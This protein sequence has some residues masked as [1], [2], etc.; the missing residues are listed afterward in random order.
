MKVTIVGYGNMGSA[1]AQGLSKAGHSV[2]VTGKDAGKAE[3]LAAKFGGRALAGS[4][5][6]R[7]ADVVIATAPYHA[8]AEA[9]AALGDLTGKVIVDISNPLKPDMSGLAVGHTTSAGEEVAAKLPG[10]KVVKAFNTVFAQALQEGPIF[11]SA[12]GQVFFAGDDAGAKDKV[13]DLIASLGFEAV[14]AGPLSNSRY[15]EPIGM[16]NIWFG[17]MAKQGTGITPAWI[18]R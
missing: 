8:Q 17:Y 13:K 1:L 6:A 5:A 3:A 2:T 11:G 16:L 15:L 9:L 7:E 18:R 12:K 14:D 10:A 4:A